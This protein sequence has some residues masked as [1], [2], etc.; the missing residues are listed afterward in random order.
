LNLLRGNEQE[1]IN[2]LNSAIERLVEKG[3]F[4]GAVLLAD[5]QNILY[6][7][8]F[9]FANIERG[10]INTIDT[11][12]NLASMNK[13]FT[14]AAIAI[15]EEQG[16]LSLNDLVKQYIPEISYESITIHQ[17]LSHTSGV[18][19]YF[20]EKF[21]ANRTNLR[22]V[23]DYLPL[24]AEDDL[25]FEP[26]TH[27]HYS[28]GGYILLGLI[29]ERLSNLS[30]FDFVRENIFTPLEMNRTDAYKSDHENPQVAIGYTNFQFDGSFKEE[31]TDH[32]SILG[33]GSPA[34]GGYSTVHDLWRFAR[35]LLDHKLL[36]SKQTAVFTTEKVNIYVD[37]D[38][39]LGYGHGFFVEKIKGCP[40]IGHDGGYPGISNRLDI[41]P[42]DNYIFIVLA[43]DD[44]G[45]AVLTREFR[46]IITSS[47][48]KLRDYS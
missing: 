12:F 1:V 4:S 14:S 25:Q 33:K 8:A 3:R 17:L 39:T 38:S 31:K 2:E 11:K 35:G 34:G 26:G 20:N 43:N 30:Y 24:F 48:R 15:L 18:G 32:L 46:K 47:S 5:R 9:G 10:I 45:G 36:S 37:D 6:N 41:Y 13:M 23:S 7:K 19:D 27:F 44:G 21:L 16:K 42:N 29:I 40:I 22:N 28:N